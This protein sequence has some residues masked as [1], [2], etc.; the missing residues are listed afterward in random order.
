[1]NNVI[2]PTNIFWGLIV[3]VWGFLG[4]FYKFFVTKQLE[5]YIRTVCEEVNCTETAFQLKKQWHVILPYAQAFCII[6]CVN[7]T[8]LKDLKAE[9]ALLHIIQPHTEKN[10]VMLKCS[11][12]KIVKG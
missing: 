1:M 6:V 9:I 5:W 11:A 3:L 7:N 10:N 8:L 12:G 4:F 2:Y